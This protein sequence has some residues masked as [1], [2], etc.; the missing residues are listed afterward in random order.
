MLDLK[1]PLQEWI[2]IDFRHQQESFAGYP[3]FQ[4]NVTP[5]GVQGNHDILKQS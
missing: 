3:R 5:V 2:A 1:G 4:D